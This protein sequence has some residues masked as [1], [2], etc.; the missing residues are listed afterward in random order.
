MEGHEIRL[1]VEYSQLD[2][3]IASLRAFL[4]KLHYSEDSLVSAEERTLL[5][6]QLDLMV[7]YRDILVQRCRLHNIKI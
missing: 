5:L 7:K 1:K 4:G 3:K 2:S 6:D